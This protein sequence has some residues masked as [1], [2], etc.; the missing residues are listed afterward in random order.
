MPR[1]PVIRERKLGKHRADGLCWNDGVIEIDERLKGKHRL[2]VLIH[3]LMHHQRPAA[4]EE[5]V[6]TQSEQMADILWKHRVRII[7]EP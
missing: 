7:D 6:D 5:E 3:E 1:K 2:R 4:T